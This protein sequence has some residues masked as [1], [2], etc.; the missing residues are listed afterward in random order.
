MS[1]SE[2]QGAGLSILFGAIG[3]YAAT[4]APTPLTKVLAAVGFGALGFFADKYFDNAGVANG[5]ATLLTNGL[6][7]GAE[8]FANAINNFLEGLYNAFTSLPGFPTVSQDLF[9]SLRLDGEEGAYGVTL[10]NNGNIWV[11]SP[12]VAN[13]IVIPEQFNPSG[14]PKSPWND[15]GPI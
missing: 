1:L 10:F 9:S 6:F 13:E 8:A 15:D 2:L 12:D 11:L 5:A 14:D 3:T 7:D 4:I